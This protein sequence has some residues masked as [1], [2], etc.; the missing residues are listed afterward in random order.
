MHIACTGDTF[1]HV[2]CLLLNAPTDQ[3]QGSLM[4]IM[5]SIFI[6]LFMEN[7]GL[8]LVEICQKNLICYWCISSWTNCLHTSSKKWLH[9][10]KNCPSSQTAMCQLQRCIYGTSY[11]LSNRF[12]LFGW[13][14]LGQIDVIEFESLA[15]RSEAFHQLTIII[16]A[17]VLV[18]HP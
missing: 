14:K 11:V 13:M 4:S 17:E 18:C 3:K 16:L 1:K 8:Y 2:S 7:P 6:G 10:E 12:F 5:S 15:N 9:K